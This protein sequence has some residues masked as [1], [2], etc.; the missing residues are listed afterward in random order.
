[1]DAHEN[2]EIARTDVC[3]D[4]VSVP[5]PGEGIVG[6]ESVDKGAASSASEPPSE[7]DEE[8]EYLEAKMR[9]ELD[10]AKRALGP[11]HGGYNAEDKRALHALER[12]EQGQTDAADKGTKRKRASVE[13]RARKRFSMVWRSGVRCW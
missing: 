3:A 6:Q 12:G 11:R 4:E 1:M 7:P 10:E 5:A 2:G 8:K 13:K 9:Q